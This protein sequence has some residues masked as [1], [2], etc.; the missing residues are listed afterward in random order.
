MCIGEIW[1]TCEGVYLLML[2]FLV[3]LV[4]LVALI[5][6]DLFAYIFEM[7]NCIRWVN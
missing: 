4:R 7:M 5:V 3:M 1:W 2:L 6:D